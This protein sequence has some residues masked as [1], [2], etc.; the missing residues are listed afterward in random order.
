[1]AARELPPLAALRAFEA[2][3]R[4]QSFT[5][6]ADELGMTQAAVSYQVKI[7]EDRIG[8]PLFVRRPRQVALTETG[9]LLAA[10]AGEAFELIAAAYANARGG[11]RATLSI[12]TVPTFAANWL[13]QRIGSFQMAHPTLAV[14]LDLSAR[15]VDLSREEFDLAIRAGRGS[16]PGLAAHFLMPVDFTPML[17]PKL[18]ATIGGVKEPADLLRLPIMD[19]DDPWWTQWLTAAGVSPDGL[20]GRAGSRMGSQAIEGG[21]AVAAQGVAM[22]T[23]AFFR[24]E[25]EDGRLIKPFDLVCDDGSAYWLVYPEARRNAPKIRAFRDWLLEELK[26]PPNPAAGF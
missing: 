2:A 7:L 25:L 13:A 23:P 24:A 8:A 14:R 3:A 10:A 9:Q 18:A 12:T 5:R 4:N 16:W 20:K 6:A 21:A 19:P 11:A 22:L 17:S 15:T 1:M 26:V